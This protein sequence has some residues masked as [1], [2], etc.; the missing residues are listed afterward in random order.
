[1]DDPTVVLTAPK[2][3]D[4]AQGGVDF[5]SPTKILGYLSPSKWVLDLVKQITGVDVLAELISPFVGHWDRVSA[6][7]DALGKV[8]QCLQGVSANVSSVGDTLDARWDGN[9]ADAAHA[10]FGSVSASLRL[11]SDAFVEAGERYQQLAVGMWHQHVAAG[12]LLTD[13]LDTT[14]EVS[15]W[16]AVGAATSETGVGAAAGYA[17]AAYKT[18]KLLRLLDE[19]KGLVSLAT[20]TAE[21]TLAVLYSLT[22]M[23][24]RTGPIATVTTPYSHP[25]VRC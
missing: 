12:H 14:V 7:G 2:A 17:M 15:I 19:W 22:K 1:M 3:A 16:A 24:D 8:S 20:S 23:I 5:F 21:G 10:F 4:P 18:L 9:A 13:V 6:Y 11:Q 25:A